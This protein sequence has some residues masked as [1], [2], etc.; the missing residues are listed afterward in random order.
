[1][2]L[3]NRDRVL[4]ILLLLVVTVTAAFWQVRSH[5]FIDFDDDYLIY[6]NAN[7]QPVTAEHLA[8]FWR[9]PFA[10]IY[11]PMTYM[12]WAGLAQVAVVTPAPGEKPISSL[13]PLYDPG[14]FH[15]FNLLLHVLSSLLVFALLRILFQSDWA[16]ALGALFWALH[17]AQVESVAWA[18][19]LKGVLAGFFSLLSLWLYAAYNARFQVGVA[20]DKQAKDAPSPRPGLYLYAL[21]VV[22]FALALLS[23]PSAAC[24]PF[25]AFL[26]D[27]WQRR[28]VRAALARTAPWLLLCLPILYMARQGQPMTEPL[29]PLWAR[30]LIALD[31]LAFYLGKVFWPFQ[32]RLEY[33]RSP[34]WVLQ[35]GLLYWTWIFPV[36]LA[37]VLWW[38]RRQ[39]PGLT[40]GFALFVAAMLPTSGLIPFVFQYYSTVADR[41]LY[42]PLLGFAAGLAWLLA[43]RP[44]RFKFGLAA[45]AMLFLAALS[46]EQTTLWGDE[47]AL[48]RHTIRLNPRSWQSR[49][50]LSLGLEEKGQTKEAIRLL[51]EAKRALPD[52]AEPYNNMGSILR[53]RGKTAAAIE[54]F[55]RATELS[56]T[57]TIAYCNLGEAYI[58]L[59]QYKYALLA[60]RRAAEL[61]PDDL[62]TQIRLVELYWRQKRYRESAAALQKA[63]SL[64]PNEASFHINAALAMTR[65]ERWPEALRHYLDAVKLLPGDPQL[66]SAVGMTLLRLNQPAQA[67][68]ALSNAVKLQPNDANYQFNLALALLKEGETSE[69]R[70][71]I[72]RALQINPNFKEARGVLQQ[73]AQAPKTRKP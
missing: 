37:G 34:Q 14:I 67:V 33:S 65:L 12:A 41:Y 49:I 72:E 58:D 5:D 52:Y 24:V 36:A 69:A 15:S 3:D 38:R 26:V 17:P 48:Y 42:L 55:V 45:T 7:Y 39:W 8:E 68:K 70:R 44:S 2:S 27:W 1:M 25:L 63:K 32:L 29:A 18:T 9:A 46:W 22:C 47:A 11:M 23:K 31:A 61:E 21:A 57:M 4:L 73:L 30:P 62:M 40:L 53:K 64:S 19:E 43:R 54:Y 71:H 16:A 50:N 35:T 56:P 10:Q 6:N 28:S 13:T 60:Y 20:S 66:H 59:K 51:R